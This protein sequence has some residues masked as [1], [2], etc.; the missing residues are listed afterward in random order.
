MTRRGRIRFGLLTASAAGG[1]LLCVVFFLGGLFGILAAARVNGESGLALQ[2][3]VH[4]YLALSATGEIKVSLWRAVWEHT[5]FPLAV[6]L[7]GFTGAGVVGI[8]LIFGIRGFL[9]AF[10]VSCFCRL[11]GWAG[12]APAAVLF[13]LPALLWVP[14]LFTLGMLG[15]RGAFAVSRREPYRFPW[16]CWGLCAVIL[17]G[18]VLLEYL[19]VS[20]LAGAVGQIVL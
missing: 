3:Y 1:L 9:F 8:P 5:R 16:R 2:K 4:A 18:C 7:L 19:A 6:W 15:M 13:G 20:R 10:G 11:F 12:L 14:V 17:W